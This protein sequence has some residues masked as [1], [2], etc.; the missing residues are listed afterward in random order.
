MHVLL[1]FSL[2]RQQAEGAVH[3]LYSQDRAS[4][5]T[6]LIN[7]PRNQISLSLGCE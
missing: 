4:W 7:S 1:A 3:F 6:R 5:S 2:V